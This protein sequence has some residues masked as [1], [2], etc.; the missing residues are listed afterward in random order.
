VGISQGSQQDP[1]GF[2]GA[3]PPDQQPPDDDQ[4]RTGFDAP[5]KRPWFGP[6]RFGYGYAPKT[7]QG[8]LIVAAGVVA[9]VVLSTLAK[10]HHFPAGLIAVPVILVVLAVRLHNWRR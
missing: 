10:S 1:E 4:F 9:V 3:V 8:Y 2:Q 6:K 5:D 7:W